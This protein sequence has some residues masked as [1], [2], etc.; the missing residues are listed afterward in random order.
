MVSLRELEKKFDPYLLQGR[1]MSELKNEDPLE[2]A[3][4]IIFWKKKIAQHGKMM[5]A[6]SHGHGRRINIQA[7]PFAELFGLVSVPADFY[8][9]SRSSASKEAFFSR[10]NTAQFCNEMRVSAFAVSSVL[11]ENRAAAIGNYQRY[12]PGA[13]PRPSR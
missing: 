2:W 8:D 3:R 6:F 13:A 10:Q 9:S 4:W 12:C 11:P 7:I 1:P 5:D